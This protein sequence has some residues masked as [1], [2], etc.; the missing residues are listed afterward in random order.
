[1]PEEMTDAA[2]RTSRRANII[3]TVVALMCV[4]VP[5]MFWKDT[6]FGRELSDDEI[7]EYLA[8]TDKPRNAQHALVQISEQMANGNLAAQQW[9]PEVLKLASHPLS[10]I[11]ITTAWVMGQ[12]REN[13]AFHAKLLAMLD[14]AEPLV[15]RNVALSL[16]RFADPAG[17][18][19]LRAMLRPFTV[20]TPHT[21]TLQNRLEPE[22]SVDHG[23][24][25]ARIEQPGVEE[26]AELRSPVPGIVKQRL[27]DDGSDVAAGDGIMLLD[28]SADHVFQALRALFLVGAQEDLD[29][30]RTF[31][32]PREGMAEHIAQ[33]ARLTADQI[34]GRAAAPPD[35]AP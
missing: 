30:V 17:R 4:V 35:R 16:A 5:F 12:D 32:R 23:T 25:L 3:V 19:V 11:R 18:P 8:D 34:R 22:D 15:R 28:P 24:L 14:D 31:M 26:A 1:M 20:T 27:L 10:E 7:R 33:Q 9:R 29:D 21:G 2:P 13:E 6:W